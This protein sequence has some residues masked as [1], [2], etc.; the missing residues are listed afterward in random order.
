MQY[1]LHN[2][3]FFLS[4][5]TKKKLDNLV[6]ESVEQQHLRVSFLDFATRKEDLNTFAKF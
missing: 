5:N 2:F 6:V 1:T 4:F 3:I